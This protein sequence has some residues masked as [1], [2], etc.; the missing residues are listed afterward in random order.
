MEQ[1]DKDVDLLESVLS[2]T[3][4]TVESVSPQQARLPTACPDFDVAK[5]VDH[6]TGWSATFAARL[7]GIESDKN[8]RA[9]HS[10]PDPGGE[11]REAGERI[12]A[13]YRD[14][15]KEAAGLPIG[16]LLMEF[17]VHGWDLASAT[18]QEPLYSDAE[19][20]RALELGH[21]LLSPDY[22]GPG[23]QFGYEVEVE[24]SAPPLDQLVAFLGRRPDWQPGTVD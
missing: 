3:A 18:G 24:D 19:A 22:R 12:V 15:T 21:E 23:Q 1:N 13:S 20:A 11:V 10:G 9:H 6:I 5:L 8:P 2:K 14:S 17:Q 7:N 4:T 16:L